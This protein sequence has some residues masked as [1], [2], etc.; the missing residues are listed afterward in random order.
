MLNDFLQINYE[1]LNLVLDWR[2]FYNTLFSVLNDNELKVEMF[3]LSE[4]RL[5]FFNLAE[6]LYIKLNKFFPQ[7]SGAEI[8]SALKPYLFFGNSKFS[9]A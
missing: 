7:G 3:T 2:H 4:K 6:K 5:N 9:A 8:F 1:K